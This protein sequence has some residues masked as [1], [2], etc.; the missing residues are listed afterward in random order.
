MIEHFIGVVNDDMDPEEVGWHAYA[1]DPD[2]TGPATRGQLSSEVAMGMQFAIIGQQEAEEEAEKLKG[3]IKDLK[4]VVRI[5]GEMLTKAFEKS[6]QHDRD[7]H[8]ALT[9]VTRLTR[10]LVEKGIISDQD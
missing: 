5:Q 1:S 7:L 6:G 3:E 9:S 10:V 4:E 8:E 2:P